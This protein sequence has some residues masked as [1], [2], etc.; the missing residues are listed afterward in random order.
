MER[1]QL[2]F[3]DESYN[4][5]T[6]ELDERDSCRF[7]LLPKDWVIPSLKFQS[8]LIMWL[9]GDTA[10]G[11]P[12]LKRLRARDV[13]HL[14]K[15]ARKTLNEMK[16]LARAISRAGTITGHWKGDNFPWTLESATILF[17]STLK[18]FE[19][20]SRI[21]GHKRRFEHM[22]WKSIHNLYLRNKKK[23]CWRS[24]CRYRK[25]EKHQTTMF[26]APGV[27]VSI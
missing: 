19:F 23:T 11:I 4:K 5:M 12:P 24:T 15:R 7:T 10:N 6:K 22:S 25:K 16:D 20:P 21:N 9:L 13:Y 2:N 14:G 17:R 1:S 8:F 26:D 18:Y 3:A 27:H